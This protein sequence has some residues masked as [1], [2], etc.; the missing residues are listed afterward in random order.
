MHYPHGQHSLFQWCDGSLTIHVR[1]SEDSCHAIPP[2][3]TCHSMQSVCLLTACLGQLVYCHLT[4]TKRMAESPLRI[5]I[6]FSTKLHQQASLSKGRL[7]PAAGYRESIAYYVS[8]AQLPSPATL[9]IVGARLRNPRPGKAGVVLTD[10]G[11]D[12]VPQNA[13]FNGFQGLCDPAHSADALL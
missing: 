13:N 10:K 1:N 12:D 11:H 7:E 9:A 8:L 6:Y 2:S 3:R 5:Q 4:F